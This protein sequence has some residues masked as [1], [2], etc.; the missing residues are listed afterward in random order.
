MGQDVYT[1]LGVSV[2]VPLTL[3]NKERIKKLVDFAMQQEDE[4]TRIAFC[5]PKSTQRRYEE[6]KA[7]ERDVLFDL[8]YDPEGMQ[9]M[10]SKEYEDEAEFKQALA[11]VGPSRENKAVE[12]LVCQQVALVA[13]SRG[14]SYRC[15]SVGSIM[16]RLEM[17]V[18][19]L[20]EALQRLE[21][22]FLDIGFAREEIQVTYDMEDSS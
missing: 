3:A 9:A 2:E 12:M 18:R 5:G 20:C 10:L 11:K 6:V 13:Y 4:N 16:T 8:E 7:E 19:G 14:I 21:Q 15:Q 22:R 1:R 17:D